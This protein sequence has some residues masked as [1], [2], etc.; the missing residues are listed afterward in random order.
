MGLVLSPGGA[1]MA[2][3]Y[4][5][6]EWFEVRLFLGGKRCLRAGWICPDEAN[7][8]GAFDCCMVENSGVSGRRESGVLFCEASGKPWRANMAL[9]YL[10][11]EWSEVCLFEGVKEVFAGSRKS[12]DG[13]DA[14][15]A[16]DCCMVENSGVSGRG[17]T[18]V[19]FCGAGGKPW[20][21]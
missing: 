20:Q 7:A 2:L 17:E 12:P 18:R 21:S 9:P 14:R 3:P 16:F 6:A 5:L 4:L 10:V 13:A 8:R 1:N 19:L 15:G 11:A